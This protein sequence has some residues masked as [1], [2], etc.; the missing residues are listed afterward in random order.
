VTTKSQ[1]GE[2]KNTASRLFKQ[3]SRGCQ[4]FVQKIEDK[5]KGASEKKRFSDDKE[6]KN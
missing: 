1:G 6:E 4:S 2:L 3:K 5:A